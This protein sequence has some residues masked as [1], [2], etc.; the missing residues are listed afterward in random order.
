[1]TMFCGLPPLR[2][3]STI[4]LAVVYLMP[5]LLAAAE[6]LTPVCTDWRRIWRCDCVGFL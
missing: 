5:T 4:F 2:H 3:L 6:M 1:M